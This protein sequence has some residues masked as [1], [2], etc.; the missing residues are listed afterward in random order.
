MVSYTA[1]LHSMKLFTWKFLLNT[2]IFQG[3]HMLL[4]LLQY[5]CV[6]YAES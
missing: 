2:H 5:F 4:V 6:K 1:N 3:H